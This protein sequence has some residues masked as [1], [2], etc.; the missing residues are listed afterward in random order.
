MDWTL[1][2]LG[3]VPEEVKGVISCMRGVIGRAK[4][5][6]LR[7]DGIYEIT[8]ESKDSLAQAY[9]ILLS[10][11]LNSV[12]MDRLSMDDIE[13]KDVENALN[14]LDDA[15]HLFSNHPFSN[16]L[17]G[18]IVEVATEANKAGLR[19]PERYASYI[20]RKLETW[21][22]PTLNYFSPND[23]GE[24]RMRDLPPEWRR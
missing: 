2:G 22:D 19:V 9:L 5:K 14:V 18:R 6:R 1:E 21:Q 23:V 7:I 10:R 13:Q 17:Y 8:N 3:T 12:F 4:S 20:D 16:V 15:R 11:S 24:S